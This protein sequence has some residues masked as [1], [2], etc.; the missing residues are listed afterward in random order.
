MATPRFNVVAVPSVFFESLED[1]RLLSAVTLSHW[2]LRVAGQANAP[3]TITVGLTPDQQ[4][5]T[6]SVAYTLPK[7]GPQLLTKTFPLS[8]VRL[9]VI[10]G[11]PQAN[12]ILIDQT[13]GSFSIPAQITTGNG[14]DTVQG[15]DEQD[16]II[17]G[18][19]NDS[20]NSGNGNDVIYGG[21]GNATLIGGSGNDWIHAGKG[22]Q[23]ILAGDGQDTLIAGTIGDTLMGGAGHDTFVAVAMKYYPANNFDA[24]KDKFK[25]KVL[26][27]SSS[28]DD[29]LLDDLLTYLL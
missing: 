25:V 2:V 18:R 13:N 3:S 9:L 29:S 17:C 19:G 27:S 14:Y 16:R 6:A 21:Y 8:K 4:S 24:S 28:S 7:K 15:G 26:P 5:V 1:R 20:I 12:S 11:G 10:H 22:H 23:E